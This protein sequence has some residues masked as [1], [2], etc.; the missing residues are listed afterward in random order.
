MDRWKLLQTLLTPFIIAFIWWIW[1][2]AKK[3]F[4]KWYNFYREAENQFRK[5][6]LEQN[7]LVVKQ[8]EEIKKEFRTN[9][10][11]SLKDDLVGMKKGLAG[12]KDDMKN[13]KDQ[14]N[15]V[16]HS[17]RL[18]REVMGEA[19]WESNSEGLV[20]YV[21]TALCEIIGCSQVE[22]LDNS[23]IGFVDPDDRK[24][25]MEDWQ[26]SVKMASEYNTEFNYKR[27]DGTF[28]RVRAAAVH[29]K[30][31]KGHV[32][33]TLGHVIKIGEPFKK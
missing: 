20:T 32:K 15:S 27:T 4:K 2:E 33:E 16:V 26:E 8:L 23:W 21:S 22:M 10:G 30:D 17:Q 3:L 31:E 24:R 25:V 11:S 9:G 28:Q 19:N 29:L 7:D 6:Q 14:L 13:M 5:Y 1:K 12:L 18:N